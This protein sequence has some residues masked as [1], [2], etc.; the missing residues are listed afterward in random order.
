MLAALKSLLAELTDGSKAE[1]FDDNDYRLASAALLVH[2]TTIDGSVADSE[3]EK[4]QAV[5]MD[6]F[7]LDQEAAS[8]LIAEAMDAEREAV[9]LHR[10][11]SLLDRVLDDAGRRRMVEM[12]WQV[13]L[14][15]GRV[16]EFED[17]L[18]WRVADLLHVPSRHRV[19]IRRQVAAA[20]AD[21]GE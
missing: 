9:D 3:R 16:N 12:L 20:Q 13:V 10:F 18:V 21:A 1:R 4:L 19:E 17:N 7:K 8:E 2:A 15:D 11:T 6:R 5:L 14:V